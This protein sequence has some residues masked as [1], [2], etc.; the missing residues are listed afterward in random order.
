MATLPYII[1]SG[2]IL[3]VL[4]L[5]YH[6]FLKRQ[7]FFQLNRFYLLG[8]L[9]LSVAI[10]F[11]PTITFSPGEGNTIPR[12]SVLLEEV[13]ALSN[14]SP[15]PISFTAILRRVYYLGVLFFGIKYL[16]ALGQLCLLYQR[17]PHKCIRGIHI[18]KRPK[19]HT[20]FSVFNY[21]FINTVA[22]DKQ[23]RNKIFEHEKIHIRQLHSIDLF[24]AEILCILNWFNPFV[25]ICR[26]DI[27]QNHEYI[28][29]KH[30]LRRFQTGSYLQ[31]LVSQT[32]GSPFSF[33]NYFSCSNLKKRMIMMTKQQTQRYKLLSYVP[34]LL[35]A[36]II[37]ISF[38]AKTTAIAAIRE[39]QPEISAESA[40]IPQS[41]TLNE[42]FSVTEQMPQF[43]GGSVQ[44]WIGKNLKYPT[45]AVT[46]AIQGKV[47]V[48]FIIE[49][50]GSIS[51]TRVVRGVDPLLDNEACRVIKAMPRW[52]PGKQRG[53]LVRVDYTLPITFSLNPSSAQKMVQPSTDNSSD[54]FTVVEDMPRFSEGIVAEWLAKNIKY[55]ASA[56][57]AKAQGKTFVTYVIEKD[58]SVSE[59]KVV[60][61]S[62]NADLDAEAIRVVS[63]MPKWIP[64]KQAGKPV[65]VDYTLPITFKLN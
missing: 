60:R 41:D 64:G 30:V 54:I 22:L 34:A 63:S 40:L 20:S 45:E 10:P 11:I 18:V 59:I 51:D 33:S 15:E 38:T 26:L 24:I 27:A 56:Q 36:G 65:R 43:I 48:K 37:F 46:K 16:W 6:L 61:S 29:D 23:S 7:T 28:A 42:V 3:V 55:P 17:S 12:Y 5:Y 47:F 4:L 52:Q 25:W 49:K 32:F 31:L 21:L 62:G 9:C 14:Y 1:K 2:G 53:Q 13:H 50:D 57:K 19:E 8:I 39:N 35:I 58:G 44:E